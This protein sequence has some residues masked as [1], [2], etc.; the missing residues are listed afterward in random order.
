M[1]LLVAG[2]ARHPKVVLVAVESP[3]R[4]VKGHGGSQVAWVPQFGQLTRRGFLAG[5]VPHDESVP[6]PGVTDVSAES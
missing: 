1:L 3:E 2:C 5:Y 4:H 6:G